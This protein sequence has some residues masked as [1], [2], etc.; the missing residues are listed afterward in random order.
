M[1]VMVVGGTMMY[2]PS[3]NLRKANPPPLKKAHVRYGMLGVRVV[4]RRGK[5]VAVNKLVRTFA[6]GI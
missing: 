3:P 4:R 1:I 6:M 5:N 2:G